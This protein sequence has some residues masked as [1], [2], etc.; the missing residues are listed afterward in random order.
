MHR[1]DELKKNMEEAVRE[2]LIFDGD[3]YAIEEAVTNA[4]YG[5][6]EKWLYCDIHG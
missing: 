1:E 5:V 4:I 2:W 3:F 6:T